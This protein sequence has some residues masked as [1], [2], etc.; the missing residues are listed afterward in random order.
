M[1]FANGKAAVITGAGSGIGRA[2][3]LQLNGEGCELYLSDIHED[4]LTETAT[5]LRQDVEAHTRVVDVADRQAMHSWAQEI[6]TR[7]T[8]VDIVVNNAGVG[9]GAT[10]ADSEYEHLDWLI[11]INLWGVIHGTKAFLPLLR[12]APQG[13]LVNISSVLGFIGMPTQSAYCAA[14]FA[15]RGFTES[16][17]HE[18]KGSNIHVCCVHPGGVLTNIAR[19]SRGSDP[20]ITAEERHEMFSKI[21]RTSPESA[22]NQIIRAMERRNKRLLIGLDAWYLSLL[23]RL[24][25]VN[26]LRFIPGIK[27]IE[28]AAE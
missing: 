10:V 4:R 6:A 27:D 5:L 26:Y 15:V 23:Y 19:T 11:N 25:P 2:L 28:Y 18:L 14:K 13:H 22:A 16:L 3:A 1:S 21:A 9:Y 8:S 20:A 7:R 17:R 12:Q 24:F